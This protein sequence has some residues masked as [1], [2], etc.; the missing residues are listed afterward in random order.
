MKHGKQIRQTEQ[1]VRTEADV[2]REQDPCAALV[3]RARKG[4]EAAFTELVRQEEKAVWL[5]ALQLTGNREDAYDVSQEA[6]LHAWRC[7]GGFRGDC[8]FRSWLLRITKNAALDLLRRRSLRAEES[9]TV[10]DAE[11]GETVQR[12]LPDEDVNADPVKAY[13]RKE[14]VR[15]V[16]QA[17]DALPE[18][19]RT[20]LVLREFRQLSYAEIGELLQI[21]PGTVKSRISRAR[22]ALKD[23][24]RGRL[25]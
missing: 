3:T 15:E 12:D 1:P 23:A 7:L 6:F 21:A 8:S 14:T 5:L 16:R 24:L 4:D 18:D 25:F 17:L 13:A 19:H 11:S 2:P 9:L 20:I 10:E 22:E